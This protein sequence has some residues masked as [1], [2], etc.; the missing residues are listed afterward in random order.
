MDRF[1]RGEDVPDA[2]LRQAWQNTAGSPATTCDLPIYENVIRAVR[3]VN[4]GH[5]KG[6]QLRVLLGD[7]PIDWESVKSTGDHQKWIDL[8][9]RHAAEVIEREVL[10]KNGGRWSSMALGT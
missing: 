7:P 4:T 10:D 2:S 9:D 5:P 1:I 6:R 3:A 8:R